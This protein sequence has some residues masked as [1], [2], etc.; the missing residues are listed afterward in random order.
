MI[1][2]LQKYNVPFVLENKAYS[3]DWLVRGRIRVN[4][5]AVK[6]DTVNTSM[7]R[8]LHFYSTLEIK[9]MQR[10]A[11]EIPTL[12]SRAERLAKE[13][14][15]LEALERT[16]DKEAKKASKSKRK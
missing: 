2:V 14:A 8:N 3:R 1:E 10:M 13:A 16:K 9:L 15:Q 5:T 11:A 6:D 7:Y 4:L 12:K